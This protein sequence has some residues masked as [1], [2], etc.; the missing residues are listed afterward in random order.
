L[1]AL[2]DRSSTTGPVIFSYESISLPR[3][4]SP[5]AL[6]LIDVPISH[7]RCHTLVAAAARTSGAAA[8]LHDGSRNRAHAGYMHPG[9]V[10]VPAG[11]ETYGHREKPVMRTRLYPVRC[12]FGALSSMD[13]SL[14]V[15]TGTEC[16][17]GPELGL[18]VCSCSPRLQLKVLR[19]ADSPTALSVL[20]WMRCL[21]VGC[22]FPLLPLFWSFW[23]LSGLWVRL[24]SFML[25]VRA[26]CKGAGSTT[27]APPY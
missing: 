1:L 24:P 5:P 16:G 11:V 17:F 18:C 25:R 20:L 4:C 22:A 7:R 3:F 6:R 10:L 15:H 26:S 12:P 9:H 13:C 2:A 19:R 23:L 14:L 27:A 8:A 21:S